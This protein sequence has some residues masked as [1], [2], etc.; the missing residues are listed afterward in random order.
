MG[1]TA[2]ITRDFARLTALCTIR[3]MTHE[4]P[5]SAPVCQCGFIESPLVL[6]W[7]DIPA[8]SHGTAINEGSPARFGFSTLTT[9]SERISNSANERNRRV[10][11]GFN[12]T[13]RFLCV[14]S[15]KQKSPNS[16]RFA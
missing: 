1:T 16:G 5:A 10:F 11:I 8:R 7:Q 9:E 13:Q 14:A 3:W 12:P 6:D 4:C 15:I 2:T